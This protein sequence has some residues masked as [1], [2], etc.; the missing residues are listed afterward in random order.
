MFAN[1]LAIFSMLSGIDVLY[2]TV[3]RLYSDNETLMALHNLHVLILKKNGVKNSDATGDGT[4]Y[5][6]TVK[7]N[8]ESYAQK[9]KELAKC[10]VYLSLGQIS[11]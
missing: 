8:Y 1:M 4:G 2:K 9:L 11:N 6:L 7:K 5:S 10:T 3:E